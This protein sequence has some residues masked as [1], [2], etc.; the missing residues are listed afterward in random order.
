MAFGA[1]WGGTRGSWNDVGPRQ[2]RRLILL[3]YAD[4]QFALAARQEADSSGAGSS[5]H[6]V[7]KRSTRDSGCDANTTPPVSQ[8]SG[9]IGALCVKR[10]PIS[11]SK[12][13]RRSQ[14]RSTS[15]AMSGLQDHCGC[16]GRDIHHPLCL[17]RRT[18]LRSFAMRAFSFSLLSIFSRDHPPMCS[19]SRASSSSSL[20]S[21]NA[22]T[23]GSM[24]V[25]R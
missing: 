17:T 8:T 10:L 19:D 23:N 22:S 6:G 11:V 7:I 1:G 14:L 2:H 25:R 20:T 3:I 4:Y 12:R 24:P 18:E 13:R 5:S 15:M 21:G 16:V 9:R